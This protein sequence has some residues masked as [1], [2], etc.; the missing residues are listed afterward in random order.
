EEFSQ[1]SHTV[2]IIP[3]LNEALDARNSPAAKP[4]ARTVKEL[5]LADTYK[6][7]R[8]VGHGILNRAKASGS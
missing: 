4:S 2:D 7:V 1:L 5:K 8:F 3:I 6:L